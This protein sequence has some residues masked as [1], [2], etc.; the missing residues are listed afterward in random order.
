MQEN[1]GDVFCEHGVVTVRFVVLY[2]SV[3]SL[4]FWHIHIVCTGNGRTDVGSEGPSTRWN[5]PKGIDYLL[6]STD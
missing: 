1:K 5:V 4:V 3:Y 2:F 6:S